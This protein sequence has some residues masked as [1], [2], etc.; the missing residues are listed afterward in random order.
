MNYFIPLDAFLYQVFD[1]YLI[2]TIHNCQHLEPETRR[3]DLHLVR[4]NLFS[5]GQTFC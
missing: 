4:V 3:T 1:Y 2:M 5:K